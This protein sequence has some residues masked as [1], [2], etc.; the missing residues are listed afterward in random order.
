[1]IIL[2]N[3]KDVMMSKQVQIIDKLSEQVLFKGSFFEIEKAYKKAQE[4]EDLGLDIEVVVPG[5]SEQLARELG[6]NEDDLSK[7]REIIHHEVE[8]HEDT[9][10]K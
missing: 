8:S 1:M 2:D 4:Y 10:C 3:N 7:L 9:C 6:A 5:I